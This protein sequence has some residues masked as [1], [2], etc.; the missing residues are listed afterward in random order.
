[1]KVKITV[2]PVEF[3]NSAT[4]AFASLEFDGVFAVSGISLIDGRKGY[5]L[6]F[7]SREGKDKDGQKKYYDIAFP[8]TAEYR[9]KLT[10]AVVKKYNDVKSKETEDGEFN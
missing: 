7:P 6:G 2:K 5:F 4:V 9:Q 3:K 8:L 10:D 1:M